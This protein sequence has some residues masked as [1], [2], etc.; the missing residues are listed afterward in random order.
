LLGRR[1]KE[2]GGEH[3]GSKGQQESRGHASQSM[4]LW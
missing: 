3:M 2:G 4:G 1:E